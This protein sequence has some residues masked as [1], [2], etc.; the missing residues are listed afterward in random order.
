MP[1][2]P[3]HKKMETTTFIPQLGKRHVTRRGLI[4]SPLRKS[5]NGT[6]YIF[7]AEVQEPECPDPSV[8]HWLENGSAIIRTHEHQDDLVGLAPEQQGDEKAGTNSTENIQLK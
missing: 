3:N 5:N 8:M 6:S 4:T 1:T 7:A 2:P